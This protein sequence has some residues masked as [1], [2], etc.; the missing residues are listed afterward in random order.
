MKEKIAKSKSRG[1]PGKE[2]STPFGDRILH[3]PWIILAAALLCDVNSWGHHFVMDDMD[4]IVRNPVIHSPA[5]ILQIF[6]APFV[7][8]PNVTLDLYR[9]L[10]ALTLAINYWISGPQPDSFHLFNRLLH[11][12]TSLGIFW[13]VRRLMP[14]RPAVAF[15][16]GLLFA[17]HPVQTEAITYISGRADALAM[18]LFVFAWLVFIR[19]RATPYRLR[20]Y[21]ISVILYFLALL[22]KESAITWLGIVLLTQWVYFSQR[23]VK[24]FFEHLRQ[25]FWRVYAGYIAATLVYVALRFSAFRGISITPTKFLVNPLVTAGF[26][27]RLLTSL[28]IF[29]VSIGQ[30]ILPVHFSPDYSFNQIPVLDHWTNGASLAVL[31]L[32]AAFLVLLGWSHK[33]SPDIFFCLGYFTVTYSVVSNLIVVIGTIRADRLLYMPAF[34]FCLL[35]GLGLAYLEE[36]ARPTVWKNPVRAAALVVLLLLAGRTVIRNRDWRDQFTLYLK[37]IRYSPDSVKMHGYLGEQYFARNQL[38]EAGEHYRFAL[39]IYPDQPDLL[40]DLGALLSRQGKSEEAIQCLRRALV[41]G[42]NDPELART[43]LGLT[44]QARGNLTEAI[45][46]FDQIIQQDPFSSGAHFNKGNALYL[47]GRV[48][49]AINEYGRALEIDPRNAGAQKNLNLALQKQTPP[50]SP[51]ERTPR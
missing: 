44:L 46:Q 28:K 24:D 31:F 35:G 18:L 17:V 29:F 51:R 9:P 16:T 39:S 2:Q 11:V 49:E 30:L 1:K 26:S 40:N 12:L 47:A 19:M 33:R 23:K 34:G 5:S 3:G 13:V 48:N 15:L 43:N 37:A 45:Q 10:T 6:T 36:T 7:H 22:S 42:P 27:G 50:P 14:Q 38:A 32:T 4:Y 25:D 8:F 41:L 21:V 20:L